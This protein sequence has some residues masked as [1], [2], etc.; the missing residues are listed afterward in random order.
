[1]TTDAREVFDLFDFWDGRDGEVD[2]FK[3][4]DL[5]RCLGRNPTN[6]VIKKHGGTEKMGRSRGLCRFLITVVLP[7]SLHCFR[8]RSF[9]TIFL[10][11]VVV[12]LS[13]CSYDRAFVELSHC[14]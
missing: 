6:A 9:V 2:A 10:I 3:L 5:L 8:S 12:D 4:G 1:M 11:V 13:L 14:F 7:D